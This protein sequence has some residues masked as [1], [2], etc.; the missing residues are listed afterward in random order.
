MLYALQETINFCE[1]FKN[2]EYYKL[3]DI[4]NITEKQE[5]EIEKKIH[6][7]LQIILKQLN[8]FGGTIK[9]ANKDLYDFQLDFATNTIYNYLFSDVLKISFYKQYD[10]WDCGIA[11]LSMMFDLTLE[12]YN[13]LFKEN[14]NIKGL[15]INKMNT[16]GKTLNANFNISKISLKTEELQI[17]QKTILLL[18][19]SN[20]QYGHYVYFD[21]THII[22]SNYDAVDHI[23]SIKDIA[24]LYPHCILL[25]SINDQKIV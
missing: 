15:S 10:K 7:D 20:I 12:K 16:I 5:Y 13:T 6:N 14:Y 19:K 18:R 2:N 9:I 3:I 24:T 11:C 1:N 17:N 22:D 8:V 25:A 4:E 23:S 21:G